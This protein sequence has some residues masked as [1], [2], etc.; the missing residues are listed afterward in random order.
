MARHDS[1]SRAPADT[2]RVRAQASE[3]ILSLAHVGVLATDAS[4]RVIYANRAAGQLLGYEP[5]EL[6]DTAIIDHTDPGVIEEARGLLERLSGGT[7]LSVDIPFKTKAG[8]LVEVAIH[9]VPHFDG[10]GRYEGAIGSIVEV[11]SQRRAAQAHEERARQLEQ[12]ANSVEAV[13][14]IADAGDAPHTTFVSPAAEAL[15]GRSP[16]QLVGS[17]KRWLACV[18]SEDRHRVE[19][20][21]R[22]LL[23]GHSDSFEEE[24]RVVLPGG[25]VRWLLEKARVDPDSVRG[26]RRVYGVA[27]DVTEQRKAEE[28]RRLLDEKLLHKQK[29]ESLGVLAGGVAHEFNNLLL[30]VIGNAEMGLHVARREDGEVARALE[31][32]LCAGQRAAVLSRQMLAYSGRGGLERRPLR[33]D[34]L[35]ENTHSMLELAAGKSARLEVTIEPELPSV[36]A[37]A[38]QIKQVLINVVTNAGEA[39]GESGGAVRVSVGVRECRGDELENPFLGT[40][41]APGSYLTL[42]VV[43]DGE[44]MD[45]T[46]LERLFDPFFST[47]FPGR[48]LGM[49]AVLGVLQ[50]HGGGINV[51]SRRGL[52]TRVEVLL[53]VIEGEAVP[54]REIRASG[55]SFEGREPVLVIDDEAVIREL[56]S[57]MLARLG[58]EAVCVASGVE[59][60]ELLRGNPRRF[61]AVILDLTMP[62]M[63]G[64]E[65]LE[66][67][68]KEAPDL[69]VIICSGYGRREM[70]ERL[71]SAMPELVLH[72]PFRLEHLRIVMRKALADSG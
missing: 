2:G 15:L 52:G 72:K 16:Q 49:S 21:R 29:L 46:T 45:P 3:R 18:H 6:V 43:D 30:A 5:E 44:G 62:R 42:E 57:K 4:E 59:G 12:L 56:A 34:R 68:R 40:P 25:E 36:L 48:G 51:E 60:L 35:V 53:P 8:D 38:E 11:G 50:G 31:E 67:I 61:S 1:G 9:V 19:A 47:R 13:L 65:A 58:L 27:T 66:Q 55:E 33:L 7:T 10:E 37:D 63:T 64:A 71:G 22:F 41:L 54:D 70:T 17:P 14:W 24:Y 32:I 26:E 69:P 23:E 39:L 28:E 20:S